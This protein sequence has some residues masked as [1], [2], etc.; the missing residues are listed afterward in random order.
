MLIANICAKINTINSIAINKHLTTT[1][2]KAVTSF[3]RVLFHVNRLS[4]QNYANRF[5]T[6][7]NSQSAYY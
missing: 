5:N 2:A 7:Y 3:F 4:T 6:D 1:Y